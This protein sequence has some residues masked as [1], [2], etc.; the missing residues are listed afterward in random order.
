MRKKLIE[1]QGEIVESS[2]VV[3]DMNI[4]LS[5]MDQSSRQRISKETVEI[6]STTNQVA[7]VDSY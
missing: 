3:G 5:E 1:L 4:H 2:G 7:T 6:N